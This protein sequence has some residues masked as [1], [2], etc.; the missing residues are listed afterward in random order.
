MIIPQS[1]GADRFYLE[2]GN[3]APTPGYQWCDSSDN[4]VTFS[5]QQLVNSDVPMQNGKMTSDFPQSEIVPALSRRSLAAL[6][7][8]LLLSAA[9]FLRAKPKARRP[10]NA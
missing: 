9:G 10:L 1:S 2:P 8:L 4:L 5:A 7:V 6:G 3:G